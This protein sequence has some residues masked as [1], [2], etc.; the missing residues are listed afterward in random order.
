MPRHRRARNLIFVMGL[1]GAL[2]ACQ[3]TTPSATPTSSSS[4][5]TSSSS[6]TATSSSPSTAPTPRATRTAAPTT[7]PAALV[8]G[9]DGLGPLKLGMDRGQAEATGMVEPFRNEPMSDRCSW[10]SR[11]TGAPAGEGIVLHSDTLGVA[12]IDAYE[13]V[14]TPEGIGIGSPVAAVDQAYPGWRD[15]V[16]GR[17][18]APVPGH[19]GIG[20]RIQDD[21]GKVSR[22]TLQYARQDCYE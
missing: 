12:T 1:V 13:G 14:R 4:T 9:P 7:I 15:N 21:D 10:R 8:L 19:D 18:W 2:T 11:L 6:S 5:A 20:Y 3:H 17:G 16:L 22:M